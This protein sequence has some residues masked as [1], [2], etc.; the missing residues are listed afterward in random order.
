MPPR[1]RLPPRRPRRVAER[2]EPPAEELG[3]RVSGEAASRSSRRGR[4]SS[5]LQLYGSVSPSLISHRRGGAYALAGAGQGPD[6]GSQGERRF[7]SKPAPQ[8]CY[9]CDD[10]GDLGH[11]RSLIP[12]RFDAERG[13]IRGGLWIFSRNSWME[14]AAATLSVWAHGPATSVRGCHRQKGA[15]CALRETA[16]DVP[17]TYWPW[18]WVYNDVW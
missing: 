18:E 10:H 6:N 2:P 9:Q 13:S 15:P 7:L 17:L 3:A 5:A 8:A 16:V 1:Q 11:L 12:S 4:S 14:G